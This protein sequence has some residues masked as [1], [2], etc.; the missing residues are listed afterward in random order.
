LGLYCSLR[1][2]NACDALAVQGGDMV[3]NDG[4]STF[5]LIAQFFRLARS[6]FS[7]EKSYV[8]QVAQNS[9]RISM[10]GLVLGVAGLV[11]VALAGIFSL[12]TL[13]LVLNTWFLPWASALIVTAVLLLGGVVLGLVGLYLVKRGIG[14]AQTGLVKAREDMRWLKKS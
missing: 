10:T 5:G 8:K 4:K 13:V 3:K 1:H 9:V 11:L 6:F 7:R 2:M 14:S 12:V